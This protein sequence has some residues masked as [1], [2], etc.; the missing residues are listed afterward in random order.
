MTGTA[1]QIIT[2]LMG[3]IKDL[4]EGTLFDIKPHSKRRSLGQNAYYWVLLAKVADAMKI[5]KPECHNEMLRAYGQPFIAG[6]AA[7]RALIPDTEEAEKKV[8][9]DATTHLAPTSQTTTLKDGKTYRTYVVMRGSHGYDTAEMTALLDGL[10]QEARQL[11][12]ETATPDELER[13]RQHD[14]QAEE[15]KSNRHSQKGKGSRLPAG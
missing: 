15:S 7:V 3:R 14:L 2:W 12:I 13:M 4:P 10:I 11:D 5:S 6:G 1:A 8:L 9:R